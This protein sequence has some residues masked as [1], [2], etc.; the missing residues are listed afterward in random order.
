MSIGD[1][2]KKWIIKA[3]PE[4]FDPTVVLTETD[5][6]ILQTWEDTVEKYGPE[7]LQESPMTWNDHELVGKW[8]GH[9]SSSFRQLGRIIYRI[10]EQV[11]TVVIVKITAE[12]DYNRRK[13]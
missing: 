1:G 4:A 5:R 2:N 10:E 12:H 3:A 8:A 11:V 7:A 9:R 13:K 6:V